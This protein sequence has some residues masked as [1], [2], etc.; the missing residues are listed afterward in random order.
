MRRPPI[1][2]KTNSWPGESDEECVQHPV[3]WRGAMIVK[4]VRSTLLPDRHLLCELDITEE[5]FASNLAI[6]NDITIASGKIS[7]KQKSISCR[8]PQSPNCKTIYVRHFELN[9]LN[10]QE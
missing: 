4:I 6:N 3:C 1:F 7:G 9:I 5:C 8:Q 10:L 2:T